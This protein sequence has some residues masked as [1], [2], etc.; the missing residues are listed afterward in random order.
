MGAICPLATTRKSY[1]TAMSGSTCPARQE[2]GLELNRDSMQP[3]NS[4]SP[5]GFSR[6]ASA[7]SLMPQRGI[8][9]AA[10]DKN[11]NCLDSSCGSLLMARSRLG[12]SS[13]RHFDV[14]QDQIGEMFLSHFKTCEAG[15]CFDDAIPISAERQA[16]HTTYLLI[17][18]D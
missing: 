17:I 18:I 2:M 5:I 9:S 15:I 1:T 11:T 6:R 8:E 7:F 4:W 12:P 3:S 16:Q 10:P 13:S 14:A